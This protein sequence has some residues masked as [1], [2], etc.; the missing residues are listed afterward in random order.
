[1]I[2]SYGKDLEHLDIQSYLQSTLEFKP[3]N[4]HAR[5]GKY[6]KF[7][8]CPECNNIHRVYHFAWSVLGCQNCNAMINKY[9]YLLE[10]N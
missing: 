6:G 9:D 4:K 1:M 7:I 10:G 2:T 3:M 5:A 8:K